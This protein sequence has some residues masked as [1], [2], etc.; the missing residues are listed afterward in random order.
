MKPRFAVLAFVFLGVALATPGRA[1]SPAVT[2]Y[3][4]IPLQAGW[5]ADGGV[6]DDCR[7][8]EPVVETP[9]P[10]WLRVRYDRTFAQLGTVSESK[11][12]GSWIDHGKLVFENDV[13]V[14]IRTTQERARTFV[15][16]FLRASRRELHQHETL[17][18]II[19]GSFT[20]GEPMK[21]VVATVPP[22]ASRAA[23]AL[24]LHR[25]F[26][27]Y[28]GGA[29]EYDDPAGIYVAASAPL[30]DVAA[31]RNALVRRGYAVRITDS[32]LL[33]SSC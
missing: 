8:S 22:R 3:L 1:A 25:I 28:A 16:A 21:R 13:H 7:F 6:P 27:R 5:K 23:G 2:V 18:E 32:T 29:S 11:G 15:P 17:A 33:T 30:G 9:L 12:P 4:H 19:G 26:D 14:T 20:G 31:L 10:H 24:E